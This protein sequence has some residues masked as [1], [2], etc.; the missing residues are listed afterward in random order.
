MANLP[1]P[2]KS[3]RQKEPRITIALGLNCLDGFVLCADSLET[4]GV[5]KRYI[6]KLWTY[7][8]HEEWGIAIAGA[9]EADL[10]DS[11]NDGLKDILGNSDF[12][13]ASLLLKL[14]T[15][16][17]RVRASYEEAEF[18]FLAIIYGLPVGYSKLF[19]VMDGSSHLGPVRK[20]QS[21][22]I[23]GGLA[24]F[25]A[26]QLYRDSISVQEGVR[27]G[28]FII[29]RVKD[30]TER[31]GGLQALSLSAGL[32]M[33][34]ALLSCGTVKRLKRLRANYLPTNSQPH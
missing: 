28:T 16:I 12:D 22:G 3:W 30:H 32:E 1:R 15:A 6:D 18:G 5:T 8:V 27:L 4:D 14:R 11:F 24:T 23:G 19:R 34:P 25:L 9:G 33:P 17:R 13:Q 29:D 21:L 7:E 31:C 2:K 26:S 20:Y 10:A